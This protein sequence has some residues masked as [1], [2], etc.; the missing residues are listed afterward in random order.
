M[1]SFFP[2]SVFCRCVALSLVVVLLLAWV[3]LFVTSL[4]RPPL[5]CLC[6]KGA[7]ASKKSLPASAFLCFVCRYMKV[8]WA[9]STE[10]VADV[11]TSHQ[12]R[13]HALVQKFCDHGI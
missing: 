6:G 5:F 9:S 10:V 8:S 4:H 3:V 11:A 1:E 2:F 7:S 12:A 13:G